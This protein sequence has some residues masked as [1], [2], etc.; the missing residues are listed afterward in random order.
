MYLGADLG[1]ATLKVALIGE[2][3]EELGAFMGR[4]P[5][6]SVRF[7]R[8]KGL[9]ADLEGR[10]AVSVKA[11]VEGGRNKTA[12]EILVWAREMGIQWVG[13]TG[14][15]AWSDQLTPEA[16]EAGEV[17]EVSESLAV[18]E[19]VRCLYPHVRS[20]FDIGR[21]TFHYQDLTRSSLGISDDDGGGGCREGMGGFLEQLAYRYG[22]T[23]EEL[24]QK[25][26]HAERAP[27]L[28]RGC[29]VFI[30]SDLTHAQQNGFELAELLRGLSE[31]V[32]AKF[33][34]RLFDGQTPPGPGV[35]LGGVAALAGV[36]QAMVRQL[37]WADEDL[38]VPELYVHCGAVGTALIGRDKKNLK[39]SSAKKP[40]LYGPAQV[41]KP[42]PRLT[43]AGVTVLAG[44]ERQSRE[45]EFTGF[46]GL[47]LGSVS[48]KVAALREDRSLAY[49][50]YRRTEGR[51]LEALKAAL[52]E[53]ENY[54]GGQATVLAA[55]CTG[56]G[57]EFCAQIAG[58]KVMADEIT[59]HRVGVIE[60]AARSG[61]GPVGSVAEIGG[62]DSK[63]IGLLN[64]L[65]FTM[66]DACAAGTGSFIE[67]QAAQMGVGLADFAALALSSDS[68]ARIGE[69]CTL[70]SANHVTE[71]LAK[72][73][74][75]ADLC[76]GLAYAAA[77]NYK[78][79]VLKG[80][81]LAP[82]VH[83]L[84]G[85]ALNSALAAALSSVLD[86]PV[87]IPPDCEVMGAVGAALIAADRRKEGT[88][89]Q[90]TG[91]K[92]L[93]LVGTPR[94][95]SCAGCENRCELNEFSVSGRKAVLG[96]RC[97]E[98]WEV[99]RISD[100][101]PLI[102]DLFKLAGD[103]FA[104]SL[105]PRPAGRLRAGLPAALTTYDWWPFWNSFFKTLGLEPVWS[106]EP[107]PE[108]IFESYSILSSPMCRNVLTAVARVNYL[109]REDRVD[110]VF[111]PS[112]DRITTAESCGLKLCPESRSIPFA[113]RQ[114]LRAGGKDGRL[115]TPLMNFSAGLPA[116]TENLSQELE[117]W[118]VSGPAVENAVGAGWAAQQKWESRKAAAGSEALDVLR[119][120]GEPGLVLA[121][122]SYLVFQRESC[123]DLP[124]KLKA[125]YGAN[126]I[127]AEFLAA[128]PSGKTADGWWWAWNIE[129][130][131][132]L[133]G[134]IE[135]L[136]LILFAMAVCPADRSLTNGI[137]TELT[138]GKFLRLEFGGHQQDAGFL[139]RCE[140]YLA[141]KDVLW[142]KK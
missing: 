88:E 85:T 12:G 6:G 87:V 10:L 127:P 130:A 49:K 75:L 55:G 64:G 61:W 62:Q 5:D 32:A 51:P 9:P 102:P 34:A 126:L 16:G 81:P 105:E 73:E 132:E 20:V 120:R 1:T 43:L 99:R 56:S 7:W 50:S 21:S 122:R 91:F 136:H 46:L 108:P 94:Q 27:A 123:L 118:G 25:A 101:K 119:R 2:S 77:A 134:S 29:S 133:V 30:R 60:A 40:R 53:M 89:S 67:E 117:P 22:L 24:G 38:A 42:W 78:K 71:R 98:R 31:T 106:P 93:G 109:L 76:A 68:P 131:A 54:F 3:P 14:S 48:L 70:A 115:I 19:A 13:L 15:G 59:A 86:R 95:F 63:F 52:G 79:M 39:K 138:K 112:V 124:K 37:K 128:G 57:R 36:R 83:F 100:R 140:A 113:L 92:E 44:P 35:F 65:D 142:P 82:M 107:F 84:G 125:R 58:I 17:S 8:P 4:M 90:F 104:E 114:S 69:F 80:R 45:K 121:G 18:R 11:R 47:D 28:S 66:N 97:G 72:G 96:S 23:L 111:F 137:L 26:A 129:R 116:L 41:P 33:A 103:A 110:F 74:P 139:T 141:G 135:E